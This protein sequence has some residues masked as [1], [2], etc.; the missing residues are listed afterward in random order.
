M[1]KL[2]FFTP[3]SKKNRIKDIDISEMEENLR[4]NSID[5][6]LNNNNNIYMNH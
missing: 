6:H 5:L 2:R 4:L 1:L 3:R